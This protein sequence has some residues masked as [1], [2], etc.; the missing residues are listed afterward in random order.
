VATRDLD[1][2]EELVELPVQEADR[3]VAHWMVPARVRRSLLLEF[4]EL[5]EVLVARGQTMGGAGGFLPETTAGEQEREW[6]AELAR[7]IG[8]DGRDLIRDLV[9]E[10]WVA[11]PWFVAE[12]FRVQRPDLYQAVEGA[13]EAGRI[14]GSTV[15]Y[16]ALMYAAL[17][18]QILLW[19]GWPPPRPRT[20]RICHR[21]FNPERAH[22][23]LV[24][25]G[26]GHTYCGPCSARS[27]EF[28]GLGVPQPL[29]SQLSDEAM[30]ERL[31]R[32]AGVLGHAPPREFRSRLQL[33]GLDPELRDRLVCALMVLPPT[34]AYL[35]RFGRPWTRVLVST[36][37]VANVRQTAR[38]TMSIARD[39][40]LCRSL[41]ERV[42]DDFLDSRRVPHDVEPAWP[43]HQTLN[44][45]G[46]LRADWL[47]SDGTLVEYVG[48]AGDSAYDKKIATKTELA[49]ITGIRLLI[50]MPHQLTDLD[51]WFKQYL[52]EP[53]ADAMK[54]SD[55][56]N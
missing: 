51:R 32:L 40:H 13:F 29:E 25:A 43:T 8:E 34:D 17:N 53:P 41:G 1:R 35:E 37:V 30:A 22:P 46:R 38:G 28:G 20:C 24:K 49:T 12:T 16:N 7:V 27:I 3:F 55:A 47:L 48:L 19:G 18:A 15:A 54:H 42:I 26:L 11:W 39:G 2:D 21:T 5:A 50:V 36:G 4:P 10:Y 45:R 31:V 23:S 56:S 44:P 33:R 52:P 6:A 9:D 14:G